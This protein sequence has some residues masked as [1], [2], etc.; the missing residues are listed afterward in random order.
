MVVTF[1][2]TVVPSSIGCGKCHRIEFEPP[3]WINKTPI[4]KQV[5]GG[6]CRPPNCSRQRSPLLFG[7]MARHFPTLSH[8]RGQKI[9]NGRLKKKIRSVHLNFIQVKLHNLFYHFQVQIF[10]EDTVGESEIQYF[11]QNDMFN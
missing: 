9:F 2:R 11:L 5:S 8:P 1:R 7:W 6:S 4:R 3:N 10:E